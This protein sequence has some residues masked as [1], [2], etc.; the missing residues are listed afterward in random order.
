M[1]AGPNSGLIDFSVPNIPGFYLLFRFWSH[2]RALYGAKHLQFIVAN[3][4][5]QP[6]PSNQLDTI[7]SASSTPRKIE[8][9]GVETDVML[10]NKDSGPAIAKEFGVDEMQVEIERAVEQVEKKLS[11]GQEK[12]TPSGRDEKKQ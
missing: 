10:L 2:Y 8:A 6:S 12:Q 5:F 1:L 4:L 9:V 7:Y 11:K 3:R